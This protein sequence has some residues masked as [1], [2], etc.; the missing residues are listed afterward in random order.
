MI[1]T[2][3][4]FRLGLLNGGYIEAEVNFDKSEEVKDSKVI[5]LYV[6]GKTFDILTKELTAF[7][8]LVGDVATKKKLLPVKMTTVRKLQRM[9]VGEFMASRDYRKGEKITYRFPWIDTQT[10]VEEVLSGAVAKH[11][12]AKKII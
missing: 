4:R 2:F 9:L 10:D 12:K 8:V 5:R 6:G 3:Q 7:L 11:L 1:D